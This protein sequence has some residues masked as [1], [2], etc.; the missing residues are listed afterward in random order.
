MTLSHMFPYF[1]TPHQNGYCQH[2]WPKVCSISSWLSMRLSKIC[3]WF[4]SVSFQITLSEILQSVLGCM[5]F[6][7][8]HLRLESL[9]LTAIWFSK[10]DALLAFKAKCF[11]GSLFQ[12]SPP[13]LG[14]SMSFWVYSLFCE[15]RCNCIILLFV[16]F[17]HTQAIRLYYTMSP[18]L[19]LVL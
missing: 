7:M 11:W 6:C 16:G 15:K 5:W 18:P 8:W 3:Q 13:G 10:K 12:Y 1:R 14:S 2:L 17:T 4:H 9:F 19:L